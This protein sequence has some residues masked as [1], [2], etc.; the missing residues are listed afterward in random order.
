MLD[1]KILEMFKIN[2]ADTNAGMHILKYVHTK[3]PNA[4]IELNF[5]KSQ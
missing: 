4:K 1:L 3:Q 5:D 2:R